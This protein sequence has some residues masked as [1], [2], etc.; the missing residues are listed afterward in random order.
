MWWAIPMFELTIEIP[1][2]LAVVGYLLAARLAL[3]A[4]GHSSH[5]Q[6]NQLHLLAFLAGVCRPEPYHQ[7]AGHAMTPNVP[8]DVRMWARLAARSRFKTTLR[9]RLWG[10]FVVASV[11][12]LLFMAGT[13][14]QTFGQRI[15]HWA[16]NPPIP[17]DYQNNV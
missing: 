4:D 2:W 7:V 9:L 12:Y 15:T 11:G 5:Q 14:T 16:A 13:A 8:P 6:T 1:V 17:K 10:R 3:L